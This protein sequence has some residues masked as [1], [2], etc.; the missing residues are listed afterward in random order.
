MINLNVPPAQELLSSSSVTATKV[1]RR[2]EGLPQSRERSFGTNAF[3]WRLNF[4]G[5]VRAWTTHSE[6]E[7]L[8]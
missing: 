8:T 6:Q 2:S 7:S 3:H 1:Y 5:S 4:P